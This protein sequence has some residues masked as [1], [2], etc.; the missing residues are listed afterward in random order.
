[1]EVFMASNPKTSIADRLL[2]A[3]VA[4]DAVLAEATLQAA[5]T[6]FGY[7]AAVMTAARG[8][9][10]QA[11]G[12]T[13]AQQAEY[14]DQ[15][16][17]TQA[18]E[19]AITA[20]YTAYMRSLQLA[21]VAFK[22]NLKGQT[23]LG[24]NGRRK[25]SLSGWLGQAETLYQGLAADPSLLAEMAKFGYDLAKVQAEAGLV[26]AVRAANVGQEREKGEAQAATKARDALLAVLDEWLADFKAVAQVALA[27]SPQQLEMLGFGAA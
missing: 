5:L 2:A 4:I 21:R 11:E 26:A 9:Y 25:E 6:P 7:D 20:A 14:G 19:A 23:A 27:D 13:A 12:Q 1:M 10:E 15:Y 8:L 22:N 17:A 3:Q 18:V 24:L 16:A